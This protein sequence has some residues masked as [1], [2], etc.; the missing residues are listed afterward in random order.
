MEVSHHGIFQRYNQDRRY[1][2]PGE[3]CKILG[4]DDADR[5]GNGGDIKMR[6]L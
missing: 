1:E 6:Y 2:V 4:E 3:G 5:W